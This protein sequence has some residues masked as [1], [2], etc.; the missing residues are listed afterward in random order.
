[1]AELFL[2]ALMAGMGVAAA[3]GPLGCLV[4]WR[5][6]AYFG[7][8]VS[9]SALF[10]VVL[11]YLLDINLTL[12]VIVFCVGF[13]WA[14]IALERSSRVPSDSLLGIL[15]HGAL[16]LGLLIVAKID[17]LQIDLMSFLFGDVLAVGTADLIII[18]ILV[19][20]V[21][22]LLY[23][24]WP[25]LLAATVNEE[26]AQ[27]EGLPVRRAHLLFVVLL[28]VVIAVGM[29]IVGVLLVVSLLIVPAAA[30]RAISKTPEQ[31]AV[32]ASVLG[33]ASV[34]LGLVL[35]FYF[36]LPSGPA[37]AVVASVFFLLSLLWPKREHRR[38]T[39]V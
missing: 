35:S 17:G 32:L 23:V 6:L 28:S 24:I 8:A 25:T 3:A 37:I 31:M 21:F 30:A 9:H 39:G 27:V 20:A 34:A 16:A 7:A 38:G 2:S 4:I 14:L 18:G 11:G 13:A 22:G 12:A 36:D 5:R 10:G 15:A 29:K 1:M 19:L 26:L 33:C